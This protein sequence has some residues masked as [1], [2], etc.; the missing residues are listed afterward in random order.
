MIVY[1]PMTPADIDE[2]RA[3][4]SATEGM[5]LRD[6]DSP[7]ALTRYLERNAG[8]SCV[9]RE[10]GCLVGVSLAGHD[11]RRGYLNHVAVASA[12]RKHGIGRKLVELC[13]AAL[14][15]HGIMK[16][17]LFVYQGNEEGKK[18]W[19]HIGWRQRGGLDLMSITL[20]DSENA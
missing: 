15:E 4:W 7:E 5:C 16:C 6:A 9:A 20:G 13:L 12:H 17:H 19:N 18:F 3:L 10:N 11:G 1:A 8:M 14:R 2:A